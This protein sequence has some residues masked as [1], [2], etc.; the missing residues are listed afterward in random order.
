M[1]SSIA[2]LLFHAG[3]M[4]DRVSRA[5]IYLGA[6]TRRLAEIQTDNARAWDAFYRSH[7]SH[8]RHLLPWEEEFIDRCV[9]PGATVLLIGCGSGRDLQP[10]VERGCQ[11]T[12]IDPSREGLALAARLID[13][14]GM[15]ATLING[16]F[17]DAPI[18]GAFDDVVF[19]YYSYSAIAMASRRVA[20]LKKAAGLL[21]PDGDVIVSLPVA[22]AR[23][24]KTL[25]RL[26]RIAGA[27]SGSD[28]R[29]EPGDFVSDN[30]EL[31]PSF[32]ISHAFAAGEL[33]R[34]AEAA[35]LRPVYHRVS[36]DGTVVAVF[37][38]T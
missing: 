6:G 33:E 4:A 22:L 3:R 21:R 35:S 26:A 25:V 15:S 9:Q 29:V 24:R 5:T 19:S 18:A 32:S 36:D 23:P 28:W 34:E 37:K 27:L 20:A 7:P 31:Q 16:H 38:R 14:R 2:L 10:L 11:V 8:D 1:R 30:R 13:A 12:G 17:E